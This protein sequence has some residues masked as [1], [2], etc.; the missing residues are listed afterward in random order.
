V[1][2]KA[3]GPPGIAE[4]PKPKKFYGARGLLDTGFFHKGVFN[5]SERRGQRCHWKNDVHII[6]PS[7]MTPRFELAIVISI[8]K[9][10]VLDISALA[11]MLRS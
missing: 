5:L 1:E 4:L 3:T 10:N 9:L 2:R 11:E 8:S 6:D 7:R